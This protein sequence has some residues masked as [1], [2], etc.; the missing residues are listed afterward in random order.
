MTTVAET[1]P[2]WAVGLNA[3]QRRAVDHQD[4]PLRI[5][6]GAGTGKTRTL[7]SRL[8][9]LIEEGVPP[10]RILLVTF[11]RRAASELVRRTGHLVEPKLAKRVE[12]GTF[13]SVAH[14][15]LR[16]YRAS[17]GLPEGFTV[18]DQG[19]ARD[20]FALLRAPVAADRQRR[21]PQTSTVAAVYSR[22]VSSQ[23]GVEETV[24]RVFPWCSADVDG[25][26]VIF[27]EYTDRKRAQQ[28]LDFDDLLLYWRAAVVDP[29]VGPV[30]A[31]MFD[32]VLVDEYQDT[33]LVQAQVLR[34]LRSA[35]SRLT[36][37]GDDAQAIYSFRAASV[38]NILDFPSHFPGSTTITLEQNY[39]SSGPILELANAV[40]AEATEGHRKRLWTDQG[41]GVRPILATCE[42]QQCQAE[43]VCA[44]ILEHHESG[45]ALRRQVVLFR[46][47]H[48][49]DLVEIELGRR[50]VPFVKYGGLRFLEAPHIRDLLSGLRLV[51]NPWDELAWL[52]MLQLADG[53]GPKSAEQ[54][55]QRLGVRDAGFAVPNPLDKFCADPTGSRSH[56]SADDLER[57]ATGLGRCRDERLATGTRV[58]LLRGV[59]E[60]MI[61]RVY[62]HPEPRLADF[63]ALAGMASDYAGIDAFLADLTLDPPS[64]TGDL[65]GKPSLDD[66][67]L[68]LST[69]HSAKGGEWDVVHLIHAADGAFPSDMATGSD[70]GV[71]EERRLF[72]VAL[73]RAKS[74]LHI[75]APLRYH[76]GDPA[77]WTDRHSY[78]QRTRFLPPEL[79][80]LMEMRA[81]RSRLDLPMPVASLPVTKAVD[82]GLG[83][84]W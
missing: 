12:A 15:I 76:H 29:E 32:H 38:R 33:S 59:L 11:S 18:M 58:E 4:G 25:L 23:V 34:A 9:R 66:D 53:V 44:S 16:R 74:H 24:A 35:D 1:D 50:G 70:E 46:T 5:I 71:D 61:R 51:E 43:A 2:A 17:L 3:E 49:S 14:R 19:D 57:L 80:C 42:D 63:D 30:M 73:T 26:K 6:A 7:V 45:M 47:S 10:E 48:H 82:V 79:D 28:L 78:A 81:V 64:S 83:G 68:T 60:P 37:V 62:D 56:R 69:V 22:V 13:H 55:M 84:L 65:A 39:R 21:F 27:T 31:S 75:Y 41:G 36:V 77:G 67:W 52:R 54:M 40:M 72:Y 8:A 20:L